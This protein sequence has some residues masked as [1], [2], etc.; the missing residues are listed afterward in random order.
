[1]EELE[2]KRFIHFFTKIENIFAIT[3]AGEETWDIWLS[4]N[5][6]TKIRHFFIKKKE[7]RCVYLFLLILG[8]KSN[9][10]PVPQN[11]RILL[12]Q[13]KDFW[14]FVFVFFF[15]YRGA[16]FYNSFLDSKNSRNLYKD[17]LSLHWRFCVLPEKEQKVQQ[18]NSA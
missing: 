9:T 14:V 11:F 7:G 16:T 15:K 12:V 13:S 8:Y 18:L 3:I 2:W 17:S 1:M 10:I 4:N 5:D 6:G